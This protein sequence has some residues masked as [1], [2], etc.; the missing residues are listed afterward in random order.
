[1]KGFPQGALPST[2]K[3]PT[4]HYLETCRLTF[5]RSDSRRSPPRFFSLRS[6]NL[7]NRCHLICHYLP[8][9]SSISYPF[10]CHVWYSCRF[11]DCNHLGWSNPF[12]GSFKC[13]FSYSNFLWS[14]SVVDGD[15]GRRLRKLHRYSRSIRRHYDPLQLLCEFRLFF[16]FVEF[17]PTD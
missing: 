14:Y 6:R 3:S 1:M 16:V 11:N 7:P 17:A 12:I 10:D 4:R 2:C 8:R 13:C 5:I 9:Q 15:A